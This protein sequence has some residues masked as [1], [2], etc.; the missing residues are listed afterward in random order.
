M[1][2]VRVTDDR[3][4]QM[5]R[6]GINGRFF[7]F[8]RNAP[9]E[10]EDVVVDNLRSLGVAFEEVSS[11][12]A[13]RSSKE[14][15]VEGGPV[16][17]GPHDVI[18]AGTMPKSLNEP[19]R[20]SPAGDQPGDL[21]DAGAELKYSNAGGTGRSVEKDAEISDIRVAAERQT[22]ADAPAAERAGEGEGGT[23]KAVTPNK[24]SGSSSKKK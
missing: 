19:G 9:V 1:K 8:P 23:K 2:T 21:T 10:V 20:L 13:G 18:S 4:G 22:K 11:K 15:S 17:T 6:M 3:Q 16:P 24:K 5:F 14:G 7:N 12:G